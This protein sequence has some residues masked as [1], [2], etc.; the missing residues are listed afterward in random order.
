MNKSTYS[1]ISQFGKGV[2]KDYST[3]PLTYCLLQTVDSGFLHGGI[4]NTIS[5]KYSK[6]CQAFMSDYCA[7]GWDDICEFASQDRTITYPNTLSRCGGPGGVECA[8]NMTAG[9][10]LV[11]N[12]ASK[13]YLSKLGGTCSIKYDPLDPTVASSP[14]VSFWEGGCNTQGNDGCVAIYEVDPSKIDNDPVMNKILSKPFIAW[15]ILVNI[16]NTAMRKGTI[17]GLKNTKLYAFF[18][19]GVFQRYLKQKSSLLKGIFTNGR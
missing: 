1:C 3:N 9:D 19:S 8:S 12:T 18:Q 11:R 5:G 13:K 10:L 4:G 7:K 2:N 14:I 16:Y 15:G 17:N 6:N